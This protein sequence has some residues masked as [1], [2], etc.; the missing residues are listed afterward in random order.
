MALEALTPRQRAVL[1]LRDV[2]DYSVKEAAQALSMGESN[3]KTTHH[4]A[5]KLMAG[6][7]QQRQD[8]GK[9]S[10]LILLKTLT[11][12]MMC[13]S[14][15]DVAGAERLL[16]AEVEGISDGGGQ[17]TAARKILRGPRK[18]AA[19]YTGLA[20][21]QKGARIS[22]RMLNGTPALV[23]RMEP[24]GH[25]WPTAFV[26]FAQLDEDGLIATLCSVLAPDKLRRLGVV[27]G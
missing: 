18:V 5:S 22:L 26:M 19:V 16:A 17:V 6:Y 27:A 4:R 20:E 11:Q 10:P 8:R 13:L 7:E 14:T 12:F 2:F 3:V 9:P 15:H 24:R 21:F 1:I 23:G 25:N